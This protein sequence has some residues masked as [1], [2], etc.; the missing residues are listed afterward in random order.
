MPDKP[1]EDIESLKIK[2]PSCGSIEWKSKAISNIP[3]TD[4]VHLYCDECGFST[5]AGNNLSESIH[6]LVEF[7]KY[8]EQKGEKEKAFNDWF[9]GQD[10]LYADDKKKA[11]LAWN[12]AVDWA[13]SKP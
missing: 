9:N 5:Q 3:S 12:A 10:F 1:I 8:K 13:R 7:I 2:C 6:Y 11:L 4:K